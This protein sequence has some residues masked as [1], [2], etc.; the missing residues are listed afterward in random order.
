MG[1]PEYLLFFLIVCEVDKI[2][3]LLVGLRKQQQI[4]AHNTVLKAEL[5]MPLTYQLVEGQ[6]ETF[7]RINLRARHSSALTDNSN[8]APAA[9]PV[10]TLV[11]YACIRR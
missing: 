10:E 9:P 5:R 7:A 11:M 4:H 6:S 8:T 3:A 1:H 2:I